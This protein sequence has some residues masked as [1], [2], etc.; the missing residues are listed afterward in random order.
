VFRHKSK[1]RVR[2]EIVILLKPTIVR[3]ERLEQ[4]TQ[5]DLDLVREMRQ[6]FSGEPL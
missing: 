2:S 4:I 5:R 3:E 6:Q 1:D